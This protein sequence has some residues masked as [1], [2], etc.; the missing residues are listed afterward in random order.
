MF[1]E[2]TNELDDALVDKQAA[3]TYSEA[4]DAVSGGDMLAEQAIKQTANVETEDGVKYVVGL[5]TTDNEYAIPSDD[6][7]DT[8][9]DEEQ[10]AEDA[11]ADDGEDEGQDTSDRIDGSQQASLDLSNEANEFYNVT[12]IA[13]DVNPERMLA[14]TS[15]G[16]DVYGARVL[17]NSHPAV[18]DGARDGVALT[19]ALA[20]DTG[21]LHEVFDILGVDARL[22]CEQVRLRVQTAFVVAHVV[23]ALDE[24]GMLDDEGP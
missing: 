7:D 5:D 9:A 17:T 13:I 3:L 22:V 21:Q 4:K 18:P 19:A 20:E 14:G 12:G 8:H 2:A 24:V 6:S 11:E 16:D 23:L 1:D 15:T 10:A